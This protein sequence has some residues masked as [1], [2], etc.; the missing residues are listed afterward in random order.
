MAYNVTPDMSTFS[1][2]INHTNIGDVSYLIGAAL[3]ILTT[4]AISN[5]RNHMKTLAF[6]IALSWHL[7]GIQQHILLLIIAAIIYVTNI[8]SLQVI[9]NTINSIQQSIGD[10]WK[11]IQG[12]EPVTNWG[13]RRKARKEKQRSNIISKEKFKYPS[14]AEINK[15][16]KQQT[17]KTPIITIKTDKEKETTPPKKYNSNFN[18]F[19]TDW[20]NKWQGEGSPT[21]RYYQRGIRE[22]FKKKG[23]QT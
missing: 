7:V 17:K 12:W 3:V 23:K 15:L 1:N 21:N 11:G 14:Q 22:Y 6:P 19:M 9:G 20:M 18:T 2:I 13:I 5:D 10:T 16:L 8:F 4:L